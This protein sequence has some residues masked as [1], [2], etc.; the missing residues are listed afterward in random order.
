MVAYTLVPMWL[1]REPGRR[2]RGGG[3]G[4]GG[5]GGV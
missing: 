3:G 1:G 2:R 4:G 5:G